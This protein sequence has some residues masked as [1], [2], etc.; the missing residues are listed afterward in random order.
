MASGGEGGVAV[1]DVGSQ[2]ADSTNAD[3]E[4]WIALTNHLRSLGFHKS[5][6]QLE[7]E[8]Q[9]KVGK[10]EMTEAEKTEV[11]LSQLSLQISGNAEE[12]V[13]GIDT[14]EDNFL[15][16]GSQDSEQDNSTWTDKEIMERYFE[17]TSRQNE[18]DDPDEPGFVRVMVSREQYYRETS[19]QSKPPGEDGVDDEDEDD[20][21][22]PGEYEASQSQHKKPRK[23]PPDH[24]CYTLKVSLNFIHC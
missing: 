6:A 12:V 9:E 14:S 19:G 8:L 13:P 16:K 17:L 5:A 20:Q 15:S 3:L 23:Y 11:L 18:W 24:G 7:E 4:P 2:I 22:K 21:E 1:E 10:P